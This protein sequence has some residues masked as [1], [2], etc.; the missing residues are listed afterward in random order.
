MELL[1]RYDVE[2]TNFSFSSD[3]PL[4]TWYS[5]VV[6]VVLYATSVFLIQK[7]VKTRTE[8]KA[9]EVVYNAFLTLLS[10]TML[11]GIL[12]AA[13]DR[14]EESFID[15]LVCSRVDP[16]QIWNGKLGF[17]TY[18]FYLSKYIELVDTIL[19]ALKQKQ[20]IF[21]HFYHHAIMLFIVYSWL[22]YPWI[23]G[24]WWCVF[25]NSFIHSIMYYYYFLSSLG[26][27][28]WWKKYLTALQSR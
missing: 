11:V 1:T 24:A 27:K 23:S 15:N 25:V 21:L 10:L 20:I 8:F 16:S 18:V 28:V 2:T 19:L 9:F 12:R 6:G 22:A 14:W 5:P 3:A 17:W 7:T 26:I 13:Y 4:A